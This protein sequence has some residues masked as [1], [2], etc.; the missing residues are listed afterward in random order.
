MKSRSFL[1]TLVIMTALYLSS[2]P[3]TAADTFIHP[4]VS[5]T[6]CVLYE[7]TS[8]WLGSMARSETPGHTRMQIRRASNSTITNNRPDGYTLDFAY[9]TIYDAASNAWDTTYYF[10][11]L[12]NN[13]SVGF[14]IVDVTSDAYVNFYTT[15]TPFGSSEY[16]TLTTGGT[17]INGVYNSNGYI[18]FGGPGSTPSGGF[19][20]T[21]GAT[22]VIN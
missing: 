19:T 9:L 7:G 22:I 15:D 2:H 10:F 13:S 11:N 17:T 6:G 1:L 21:G 4:P 18:Q 20:I 3:A 16:G 5:C 14:V 12:P 8:C